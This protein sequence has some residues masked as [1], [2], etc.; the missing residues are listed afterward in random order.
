MKTGITII[1]GIFIL[2]AMTIVLAV[3]NQ[4]SIENAEVLITTSCIQCHNQDL[5]E[6]RGKKQQRVGPNRIP[7]DHKLR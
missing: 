2:T 6:T 1:I 7:Y 5:K 3:T 4:T